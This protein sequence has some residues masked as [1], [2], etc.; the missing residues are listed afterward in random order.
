VRIL[1]FPILLLQAV[2]AF[3]QPT[4]SAEIVSDPLPRQ[5]TAA[6]FNAPAVAMARDRRGALIAWAMPSEGYDRI[7]VAR[8]DATGHIAGAVRRVPVASPYLVEVIAP[9]VAADPSGRGF[10]IAWLELPD[11]YP[12]S[13]LAVYCRLDEDLNPSVPSALPILNALASS[14]PIVRSGKT[15]W[16]AVEDQ[17][18]QIRADGSVS[19][20]L[21][22]GIPVSD[23]TVGTDFPQ[24]VS[25]HVASTRTFTC[26]QG[27]NCTG[28]GFFGN[29]LCP[30]TTF[31]DSYVLQFVS[32]Y[33]LSAAQEFAFDSSK[34]RPAI[35]S[36]GRDA[37]IAW[38]RGKEAN[39]GD[40]VAAR[41]APPGFVD[42]AQATQQTTVLGRFG[43]NAG[44][45]RPDVAGDG[46]H[47]LVVWRTPNDGG[48]QDILGA[49]I[50]RA[51]NVIPLSIA[52]TA[53]EARDPSVIAIGPG[54]FLVAYEKISSVDRRIAGRFVTFEE[55]THAVR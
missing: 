36:D 24:V 52:T 25:G 18:W 31:T 44:L 17:V 55:R 39:G 3:A 41:L 43:R 1:L 29:C 38:F 34:A 13:T 2:A 45:T 14:P 20:P 35:R 30:I 11:T 42:F 9:S 19:S 12:Q 54:K 22:V 4:V 37:M 16:L 6:T 10:T 53:A 15:T 32:L 5:L 8:L 28:H 48:D 46:E 7:F 21:N 51:G 50:D 33:T 47:Y 26:G 23:M 27:P 49:S 40:V